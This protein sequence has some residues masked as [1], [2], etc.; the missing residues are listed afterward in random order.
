MFL[1][2]VQVQDRALLPAAA[3]L[4]VALASARALLDQPGGPTAA[5]LLRDVTIPAPLLLAAPHSQ[6]ARAVT[7]QVAAAGGSLRLAGGATVHMAASFASCAAVAGQR[8]SMPARLALLLPH[9]QRPAISSPGLIVV[10][11]LAAHGDSGG[12]A[13]EYWMHPSAVDASIHAGTALN[14]SGQ[15]HPLSVPTGLAALAAPV[16]LGSSAAWA[17]AGNVSAAADG[18]ATSNFMAA[19]GTAAGRTAARLH[20]LQSRPMPVQ[21]ASAARSGSTRL[22]YQVQWRAAQPTEVVP[23]GQE[24]RSTASC[25]AHTQLAWLAKQPGQAASRWLQPTAGSPAAVVSGAIAWLQVGAAQ[26][27]HQQRSIGLHATAT[28]VEGPATVCRSERGSCGVA[29]VGVAGLLRTVARE[30]PAGRF[31]SLLSSSW[32]TYPPALHTPGEGAD[33][34]GSAAAGGLLLLP[35]LTAFAAG[36]H[37]QRQQDLRALATS[38]P[39]L[40][41]RV[42]VSGGLGDLGMLVGAWLAQQ[43]PGAHAV[44]LGRAAHSRQWPAAVLAGGGLVSAA[45]AD[46]ASREDV[47]AMSACSGTSRKPLCGVVHAGGLLADAMLARQTGASVRAVLAPKVLGGRLLLQ[48]AAAAP[49]QLSALF[50]ST[51]AL[52]GP[53]GQAN[54]AAANAMLGALAAHQRQSGHSSMSI[55]W[56]AWSVGMA[57][58]DGALLARIQSSGMGLIAPAAGLQALAHMMALQPSSSSMLPPALVA[59]PFDWPRLRQAASGAVPLMFEE[60]STEASSNAVVAASQPSQLAVLQGAASG[61]MAGRAPSAAEVSRQIA[62]L[63]RASLGA[64]VNGQGTVWGIACTQLFR[65]CVLTAQLLTC[66]AGATRC[67]AHVCRP[68]QPGSGGAAQQPAVCIWAAAA[69]H[70]RL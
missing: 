9:N 56:G 49:L 68:G 14:P 34:Y 5:P 39:G 6:S 3:M 27:G 41:G 25:A 31:H 33:A 22:L 54:Y 40:T 17:A 32:S 15:G 10:A 67:A 52:I 7:C 43:Q 70:R 37:E 66:H 42:L 64:E 18:S 2:P 8:T 23:P 58:R 65:M 61:S 57:G 13:F 63:V 24:E 11:H 28:A 48:L 51:A 12:A 59:S 16:R 36:G 60:F 20:E 46:V 35:R 53:A 30:Q 21:S 69:S 4:E 44:L 45:M 29:A 62:E 1:L 55:L 38:A 19:P 50:S 26:G 47:A